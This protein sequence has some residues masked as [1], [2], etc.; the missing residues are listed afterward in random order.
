MAE[1]SSSRG[2][3]LFGLFMAHIGYN[4][5]VVVEKFLRAHTVVKHLPDGQ[6]MLLRPWLG[7]TGAMSEVWEQEVYAPVGK[8]RDGEIIMDVGGHVG[9]FS[10][11]AAPKVGGSGRV[12]TVEPDPA[13][14]QMLRRNVSRNKHKNVT[15]LQVGLS[16]HSG[17]ATF[18]R[19]PQYSGA[20]HLQND[21]DSTRVEGSSITVELTTMD[22]IVK[23]QGIQRLDMVKMDCEG[24]EL[25]ALRGGTETLRRFHPRIAMEYHPPKC[26]SPPTEVKSFLESL[27]Y[28]VR[29]VGTETQ[30]IFYAN[31]KKDAKS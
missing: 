22:E 6:S 4:G 27:G 20:N 23:A 2:R 3:W 31:L 24:A 15:I 16:D 18:R 25:G 5:R 9:S 30:G 1:T 17:T 26:G 10:L 21:L 8:P 28:G 13:N 29:G 19:D 11:W 14:A 12:I 7:E